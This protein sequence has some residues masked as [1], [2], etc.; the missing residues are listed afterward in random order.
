MR[1]SGPG[2]TFHGST[3]CVQSVLAA[4]FRDSHNSFPEF[5]GISAT[6]VQEISV[7]FRK[8]LPSTQIKFRERGEVA[9]FWMAF[10]VS[11]I[12]LYVHL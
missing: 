6:Y 2:G 9:K 11:H 12:R 5:P 10:R 7:Y 1:S 3:H 8:S 4:Y